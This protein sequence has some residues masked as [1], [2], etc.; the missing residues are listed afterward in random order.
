[1]YLTDYASELINESKSNRIN[2]KCKFDQLIKTLLENDVRF[3]VKSPN[4]AFNVIRRNEEN[5]MY[6]SNKN[7]LF[8]YD[9]E[10]FLI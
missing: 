2:R 9:G 6:I 5:N 7:R 8:A 4:V 1:M 3:Q 10:F